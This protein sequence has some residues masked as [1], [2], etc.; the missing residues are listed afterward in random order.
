MDDHTRTDERTVLDGRDLG[1][2]WAVG[3]YVDGL[4]QTAMARAGSSGDR[5]AMLAHIASAGPLATTELAAALG[6]PFMTASDHV[7]R[8]IATGEIRRI[9]HPTDG[10]SKLVEVTASGSRRYRTAE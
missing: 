9:P 2:L 3:Q 7:D 5:L 1:D 10:R 4:V 8:L 6:I